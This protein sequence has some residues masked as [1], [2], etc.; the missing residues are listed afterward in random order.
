MNIISAHGQGGAE[1]AGLLSTHIDV[2]TSE[3]AA[4]LT[5]GGR[6]MSLDGGLL[7]QYLTK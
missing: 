5:K 2:A 1:T 6:K 4:L 7:K 3:L